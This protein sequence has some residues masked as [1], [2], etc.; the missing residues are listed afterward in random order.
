[1]DIDTSPGQV[2]AWI[3][4]KLSLLNHRKIF[5]LRRLAKFETRREAIGCVVSLILFTLQNAW[6]D[7]DLSPWTKEDLEEFLEWRGE[8]GYLIEALQNCGK[9][10]E[11]EPGFLV[12]MKVNDWEVHA[13]RLIDGRLGRKDRYWRARGGPPQPQVK[14]K[15]DGPTPKEKADAEIERRKKTEKKA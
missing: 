14:P 1:M 11:A 13:K 10:D 15:L 9:D 2:D 8:P 3:P 5:K 12:G 7:G 4:L 6:K